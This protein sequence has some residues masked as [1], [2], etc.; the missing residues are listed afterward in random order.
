MN[1]SRAN[2]DLLFRNGLKDVEV[3]PPVEVWVNIR[4]VIRKK[5]NPFIIL[6]AAALIT[7]LLSLSF[8]AY[9]WSRELSTTLD[10]PLITLNEESVAPERVNTV[11]PLQLIPESRRAEIQ[12]GDS[13]MPDQ[14]AVTAEVSDNYID[15]G[16]VVFNPET[17]NHSIRESRFSPE[18]VLAV[19]NNGNNKNFGIDDLKGQ[20]YYDNTGTERKPKWSVAAMA[21]PT[22]YSGFGS[23]N[24]DLAKQIM[25]SEQAQVSYSGGVA[26]S[27]KLSKKFSIQSGIYYSS[28]GQIVG[29]ISS[30]G[31]FQQ[32]D[33]TK[34]DPNFRVFTSSGTIYTDN[35]DVFLLD[36]MGERII[37][38]YTND[39]F[40]PFKSSLQYLNNSLHQRFNYLE[41]PVILRYKLVDRA[42][43]LNLIGG[44]SY[45]LLLYNSVYT[46][47]DGS[48]YL[49]GK[50]EGLNPI[51]FSSS[52]GMGMEYSLSD[53]LSLNLEPTFRYYLKP[54][55]EIS[56]INTHPYSFGIFSGLSYKF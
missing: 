16:A 4:P 5:Q 48:R 50:T 47:F 20:D 35:A 10:S 51:I 45:N 9:R 1:E 12:L 49:I 19:R 38:M 7:V 21:S 44:L 27:Y 53:K 13:E 2:I 42:I 24:D 15:T 23:G 8:L 28:V 18:P 17:N 55:S 25:S 56:G 26:F 33:Y 37:T 41:M 46:T 54:F 40:D 32:Y 34:G 39:V 36:A 6:R 3:L 29:G 11:Q 52:L 31:G 22:Y 14:A 43:D 30:F